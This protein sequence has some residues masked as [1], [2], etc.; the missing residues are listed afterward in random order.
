MNDTG[1]T[2]PDTKTLKNAFERK[3]MFFEAGATKAYKFRMQALK[4]LYEA[5]KKYEP[6]ILAALKADMRKP[7]FEG[8]GGDVGVVLQEI[9]AFRKN[10]R[11][12][13]RYEERPTSIALWP[14]KSKLTY[15]PL[16]VVLIIGPW[17]YPFLLP[18]TPLAAAIAAGN[19]AIVKPSELAPA[20]ALVVEKIIRE[21][22]DEQHVSVVQGDG[23]EIVPA[24]MRAFRFDHVFFTGSV[25]V[26][27]EI[28]KLA[29]EK[30]I[31]TTLELGGKSP[32][33][34]DRNTDLELTAKRIVWGKYF[35]AGQ[36][37][38][39]PDYALV[40]EESADDFVEHCKKYI[41]R[42]FGENPQES[43]DFAR[44][45]HRRHFDKICRYLSQ[46]K[47]LHGGKTDPDDLYI[48]PAILGD[49]TLNDTVMQEEIFGPVLPV[50]TYKN[51]DEALD[52]IRQNP[53]PLS[54]YLFTTSQ[55]TQQLVVNS[56]P[57]GNGV[58]NQTLVQFTNPDL[59][60]G[61]VATSGMGRYHGYEGFLAFSN[62]KSLMEFGFLFDNPLLYPPYKKWQLKLAKWFLR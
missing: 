15:E 25:A 48:E 32:A 41:N 34:V 23:A 11:R 40:S 56:L 4:R 54:L 18:L 59:P 14:V 45:I 28:A 53:N 5:V 60:F 44:I 38:I 50:L 35:N 26:G 46:G 22:F 57:F 52:I 21:T 49:I 33:L 31:P 13:M 58:I 51:L 39:A 7:D 3:K 17:N 2:A 16:G 24:M 42:F 61:G 19:C 10:L 20:S 6:E 37:C 47:L 1:I 36:T 12:W 27:R 43:A 55:R 29:A 30:L 9:S 8:F 62:K